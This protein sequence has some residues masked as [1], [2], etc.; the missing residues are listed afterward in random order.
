MSNHHQLW[1]EIAFPL[2]ECSDLFTFY[3]RQSKLRTLDASGPSAPSPFLRDRYARQHTYLRLSLTERCS[4]RCLY[5]M[6]ADG[7]PLTPKPQLLTQPEL[8]R[9]A[10]LFVQQ[11]VNKIRL[12]GGEPT[13]RKDLVD[14]VGECAV[15]GRMRV[16]E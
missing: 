8:A 4:L 12:T 13:V 10:N 14:V 5:C 9:L 1:V 2:S 16:R 11:G 15:C 3:P 6:P 7:V